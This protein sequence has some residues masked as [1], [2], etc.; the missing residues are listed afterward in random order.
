MFEIN[1][2]DLIPKELR[3]QAQ[4]ALVD[5]VS[6]QA[7]KYIDERTAEKIKKLRTDGAFRRKFEQGL[8]RALKRFVDE[9]YEQDEDLVEAIVEDTSLFEKP[10]VKQAL[11]TMLKK[12]GSYLVEEGETVAHS[13]ESVL[14]RR[15]NRERVNKAMVYLMRCLVEELWHLPELQPVYSLQFQKLTAEATKH[16]VEIQKAQLQALTTMNDG[17][18]QALMQLTDAIG[19]QK[20]L[21]E[22]GQDIEPDQQIFHNLPNPEYGKFIGREKELEKIHEILK[23]YPKSQHSLVTIDG[24]GGI[25]KSA[26]ALEAA[27]H[28]LRNYAQLPIDERF[29]A[30]IWT[31][32]K[33]TIL[34]AE[35]IKTRHQALHTLEDIYSLIAVALQREDITRA[36]PEEQAE[37]VRHALARQR[38]LLIIDNLET[39]DD[40]AVMAFLHELPAPTKAIVT[41]RHRIDVAYPVRLVGMPWE[42]AQSLIEQECN[43]KGVTL[44][45]EEAQRLY[46]RTGGVPLAIVWSIAQMGFG[47]QIGSVLKRLG[48][49]TS[50]IASFCFEGTMTSIRGK[51]PHEVLMALSMFVTDGSRAALGNITTL[52]ALELDDGLVM[53][54]KL[55]LINKRSNRFSLLP[56]TK[57]F[58]EN[59]LK[60]HPDFEERARRN[61]VD[62]YKT[63]FKFSEDEI[64][65]RYKG[66]EFYEEGENLRDA[67]EW[68][69]LAGTADDVFILTLLSSDYFDDTGRWNELLSYCRRALSL[70]RTTQD[71]VNIGRFS[72]KIGWFLEQRGEYE[73]ALE[74]AK[75]SN[76]YYQE[77]G[78][79]KGIGKSLQRLSAIYRKQGNFDIS[80]ELCN[81]AYNIAKEINDGNLELLILHEY[82]KLARAQQDWEGA[83]K[84]F[85]TVQQKFEK[86]AEETPHDE[87][88]SWGVAG[89]LAIVE[90]HLGNPEKAK[91]LCLRSLEFFEQH[92]TR[93]YLGVLKYRL[94][95]AEEALGEF[96]AA[97]VHV[98]E[99]L[100]WFDRLGMKPDYAE[101]LPLLE[102]LETV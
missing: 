15:R 60:S 41:T 25:G 53:L 93:G 17:V 76:K 2:S 84:Y 59:E 81:Q 82:G 12:P 33:R 50:D 74:A 90:L 62:Y 67:I 38:T 66:P 5:F 79:K 70:A 26:L 95:L 99:A 57:S 45:Q 32:A 39:V 92:G 97:K 87:Q 48:N 51:A 100:D 77:A 68:A 80:I 83:K 9:Y 63:S 40:E 85:T 7:K 96:D 23:P 46:K 13:F 72:N 42:D 22:P 71:F 64:I 44:T 65:W 16:Q 37:V 88:L 43:K 101:A 18:R 8:E 34:T 1:V 47:Y 98:E 20:L 61:W 73:D 24:I 28:Y 11:M 94:A 31:S 58:A 102:R 6:E 3:Q 21:P 54:E 35:G 30:I 56:L 91:E 10:D 36:R 55:S 52:P 27:N 14:P 29:D 86:I 69:Y 75:E 19:Q 78:D 4:D 89:H 49:P